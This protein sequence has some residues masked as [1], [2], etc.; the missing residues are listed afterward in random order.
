VKNHP[1]TLI[2]FFRANDARVFA[3]EIERSEA[4][5]ILPMFREIQEWIDTFEQHLP[6]ESS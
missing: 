2:T 5:R 6:K 4:S 1:W 3:R